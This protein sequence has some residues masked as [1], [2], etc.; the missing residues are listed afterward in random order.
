MAALVRLTKARRNTLKAYSPAMRDD[1]IA[2]LSLN[3]FR[4]AAEEA[5]LNYLLGLQRT[6]A[7]ARPVATHPALHAPYGKG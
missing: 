4:T 3:P 7:K 2:R 5:E 6:N 1:A